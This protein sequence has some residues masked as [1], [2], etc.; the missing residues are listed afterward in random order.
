[1]KDIYIYPMLRCLPIAMD[2]T[3][4]FFR[5]RYD[6]LRPFYMT[7]TGNITSTPVRNDHALPT[8]ET[9]DKSIHRPKMSVVELIDRGQR[10]KNKKI[11]S[12]GKYELS[13]LPTYRQQREHPTADILISRDALSDDDACLLGCAHLACTP[14]ASGVHV[15]A[16]R[17]TE[18]IITYQPA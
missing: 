16:Q 8:D 18:S 5:I 17:I 15:F 3:A 14:R 1:M 10:R 7:I 2:W 6:V 13:R 11:P 12:N 4:W 9:N